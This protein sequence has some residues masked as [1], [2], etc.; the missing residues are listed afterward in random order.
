M[1]R[2]PRR[3]TTS[4]HSPAR[5]AQPPLPD[6]PLAGAP[7]DAK[8]WLYRKPVQMARAGVQELELDPEALARARPDFADL[9]LLRAGNQIPYV[10]EQPVLARSL[11]LT[12]VATPDPKRPALSRWRITL[13]QANLPL[14]RL[15]LSSKT[16]LFS[17]QFRVFEISAGPNGNRQEKPLAADEWSRTPEPGVPETRAIELWD[18][19]HTDTLWLE[20]DNG[21]NPAIALGTVQ[22]TY[23]VVRLVFK[24]AETDGYALA[25]GNATAVA[26][27]YDLSLVAVKL[28]TASRNVA[29]IAAGEENPAARKSLFSLDRRFLLWGSLSLV[30]IVLLVV[31]ARLLPKP[32]AA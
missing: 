5:C 29:Q 3:G 8:E 13:P 14:R 15:I 9:R 18:Q 26:P 19:P 1:P 20:A 4:P 7:L 31:V 23:P 12:P 27:R 17:R 2:P 21:D 24:A 11:T 32:P 28:L 6:V 10:L 30:V 25:Y 16:P 22:T